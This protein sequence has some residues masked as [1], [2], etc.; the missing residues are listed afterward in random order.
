MAVVS[1]ADQEEQ[2]WADSF[3][4]VKKSAQEERKRHIV[5]LEMTSHLSFSD[6]EEVMR[7]CAYLYDAGYRKQAPP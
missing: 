3:R 2:Q 1:F 5:I 4:T 7:T 6:K